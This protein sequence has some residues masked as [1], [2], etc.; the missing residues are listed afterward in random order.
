M[1]GSGMAE[2]PY[3]I[4]MFT[5]A[6]IISEDPWEW[7]YQ[8]AVFPVVD[9][10]NPWAW[11]LVYWAEEILQSI[12]EHYPGIQRSQV[13]WFAGRPLLTQEDF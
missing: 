3:P 8:T 5:G 2:H 12:E 9:A 11:A 1:R 10:D 13:H 4:I 6:V 7:A